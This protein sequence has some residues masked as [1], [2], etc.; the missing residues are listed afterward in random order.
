MQDP[1]IPNR[2]TDN[3]YP[4]C[5]SSCT[6][7]KPF[8]LKSVFAGALVAVGLT[9]LFNLLTLGLGFSLFT[10]H[11]AGKV[12]LGFAGIAW[13]L[14]GSYIILFI[15]GWVAGRLVA[16]QDSSHVC[17]G[18]LHGFST[19]CLYLIMSWV[20][21]FF[22]KDPLSAAMMKSFFIN[23]VPET[24]NP[25]INE[26]GYAGLITFAIFLMGAL[27]ATIG[28]ACGIKACKK[29]SC[30]KCCGENKYQNK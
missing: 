17:C 12:T 23:L 20:L 7:K 11:E 6:Q 3:N 5:T 14:V 26:L 15:P 18:F 19:W 29:C 16:H 21:L 22:M 1:V 30:A 4:V 24:T 28:G 13:M 27:G 25:Q 2:V 10:P 8:C 9:F